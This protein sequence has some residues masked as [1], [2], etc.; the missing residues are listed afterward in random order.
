MIRLRRQLQLPATLT[1][2]GIGRKDLE[3]A[4]D[5]LIRAALQDPCLFGNPRPATAQDMEKLLREAAE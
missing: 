1:E 3:A 4:S 5:G 2:A